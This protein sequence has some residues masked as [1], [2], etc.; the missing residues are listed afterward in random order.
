VLIVDSSL[1]FF[2]WVLGGLLFWG[3]LVPGFFGLVCFGLYVSSF[4][5]CLSQSPCFQA[6]LNPT[7]GDTRIPFSRVAPSSD[8]L[9][10]IFQTSQSASLSPSPLRGVFFY[11]LSQTFSFSY[12]SNSFRSALYPH[13][14]GFFFWGSLLAV[15]CPRTALPFDELDEALLFSPP[16]S[17]TGLS[18][19]ASTP[20]WPS[21]LAVLVLLRLTGLFF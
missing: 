3:F 1:S 16:R 17:A 6:V 4:L 12:F 15:V 8:L 14:R 9:A 7:A 10:T 5:G 13:P 20:H 21:H 11:F 18:T 19:R 2:F